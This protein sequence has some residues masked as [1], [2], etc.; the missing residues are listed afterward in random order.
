MAVYS[1]IWKDLYYT[2][3]ADSLAYEITYQSNTIFSGKAYA[4]PGS[5][6][7]ININ[8][9]CADYLFQTIDFT[10]SNGYNGNAS[11]TFYL[12]SNGS[13]LQTYVFLYCWDYDFDWTG[14]NATLSQPICDVYGSGML[15]PTTTVSS[16]SVRTALNSAT[17]VTGCVE[18]GLYYVNRRG[19]W[20]ALAIQGN[21]KVSDKITQ[22]TTDN[23]FDNTTRDFEAN[24]Y[25]AEIKTNYEFHT[26]YLSD[27]QSENLAKNLLSTNKLYIHNLKEGTIEPALITDTSVNYQRYKT[28]GRKMASYTIN[29]VLSQSKLRR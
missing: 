24:R 7:K 15:V 14:G 29:A 22:Y 2:S 19:G 10:N 18:Y 11:G 6:I 16:S 1:P 27:E 5:S 21:T 4:M 13:T 28:N 8:K 12:K 26:H 23:S 20:D 17:T 25:L 9:V 3:N